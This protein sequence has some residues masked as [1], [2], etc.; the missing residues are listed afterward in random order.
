MADNHVCDRPRDVRRC[1]SAPVGTHYDHVGVG[2]SG[3]FEDRFGGRP[4]FHYDFM[5][6]IR[7]LR[8]KVYQLLP[9]VAAEPAALDYALAAFLNGMQKNSKG[10]REL[11]A[12]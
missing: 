11:P 2:I 5:A 7:I 9:D 3:H 4:T 8:H 6:D 10:V 12:M 1:G